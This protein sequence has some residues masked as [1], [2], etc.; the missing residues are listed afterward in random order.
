MCLSQ[1]LH[2]LQSEH[3]GSASYFDDQRHTLKLTTYLC[4]EFFKQFHRIPSGSD[5][6]SKRHG[7]KAELKHFRWDK[8]G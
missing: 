5:D 2:I 1:L 6:P 4:S 3:D 8:D 7:T